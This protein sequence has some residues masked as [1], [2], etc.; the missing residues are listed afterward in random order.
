[1]AAYLIA[2][3]RITD[4]EAY[5]AYPPLAAETLAPH[6]AEALVVDFDSEAVEGDSNAVTVVLKFE[7]REA[8]RAWYASEDYRKIKHLRSDN[9]EGFLLIAD[10]LEGA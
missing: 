2:N 1:M 10:G 9:T 7:S 6:G 4:P 3:Y 8:A 5:A